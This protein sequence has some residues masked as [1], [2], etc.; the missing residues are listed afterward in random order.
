[1]KFLRIAILFG[2]TLAL[3]GGAIYWSR[4]PA[5]YTTPADCLESYAEA[6][7]QADAARLQKC[8]SEPLRS[9]LQ[10][11]GTDAGGLAAALQKE[12]KDIKSWVQCLEQLTDES[13]AVID[14]DE[15]R[16]SGTRRIRF[17]LERTRRGWL[18]TAIDPPKDIPQT[19]PYAV[20]IRDASPD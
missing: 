1:M 17:H 7:R 6:V 8:L 19:I 16:S 9:E 12:A 14:V 10:K 3:L 4:I 15:V 13:N 2:L 18:I 5:G 20:H 11:R